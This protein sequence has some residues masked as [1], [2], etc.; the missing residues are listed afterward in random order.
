MLEGKDA[1]S[2][3]EPTGDQF[4]VDNAA[5]GF[6]FA[7]ERLSGDRCHTHR[8]VDGSAEIG[9][10]SQGWTGAYGRAWRKGGADFGCHQVASLGVVG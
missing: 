5:A 10:G 7:L 2:D 1:C 8:F 6:D 9:A 3:V 4:F